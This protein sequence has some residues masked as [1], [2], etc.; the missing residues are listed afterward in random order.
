MAELPLLMVVCTGN[1]CRSPM[2]EAVLRYQVQQR[3]LAARV[4]SS[5]LEAPDRKSVV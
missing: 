1:I 4:E 2:A 3:G 5:G